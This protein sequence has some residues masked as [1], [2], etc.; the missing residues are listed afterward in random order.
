ML[1]VYRHLFQF[2]VAWGATT[3]LPWA[4]WGCT[5]TWYLFRWSKITWSWFF[6]YSYRFLRWWASCRQEVWIFQLSVGVKAS[7]VESQRM[8]S[9][10]FISFHRLSFWTTLMFLSFCIHFL[11]CCINFLS[12][13]FHVLSCSV[14]MYRRYKSSKADMLKP[15]RWVSAQTL[16]FFFIFRYRS[17]WSFSYRFGGLCRLPFSG[18]MN[19]YMY[20]IISSLSFFTRIVFWAGN[21]L[22]VLRCKPSSNEMPEVINIP[23]NYYHHFL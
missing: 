19:M 9:V 1:G 23:Y 16:A 5:K 10:V 4:I 22:A 6:F 8:Q 11:S 21:A 3:D 14:A 17:L 18:F 13:C 15:V 12:F 2:D 20:K 7:L